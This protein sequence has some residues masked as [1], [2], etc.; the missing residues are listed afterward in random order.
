MGYALA[1]SRFC[2]LLSRKR[3]SESIYNI[4]E[5][6]APVDGQ[7]RGA[8][9]WPDQ[10]SE[11][12]PSLPYIAFQDHAVVNPNRWWSSVDMGR[13]GVPRPS[14]EPVARLLKGVLHCRA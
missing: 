3:L 11:C 1:R 6:R 14:R 12:L 9:A 8:D 13:D 10:S 4:D 5:M 7:R 2:R